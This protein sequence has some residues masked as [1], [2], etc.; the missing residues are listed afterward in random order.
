MWTAALLI[1][2]QSFLYGY[3]LAALNACLV[4]G[5]GNDSEACF[6]NDDNN[7]GGSCP[8]G[9]IY[10]D[11]NL[12]TIETSLATALMIVGA[13]AGSVFGSYPSELYGRRQT[14][15]INSLFFFLGGALSGSGNVVA[16]FIGRI[17]SGFGSGVVSCLCPVLL[18]E[19]ASE[20][21]RGIIT[22]M[23]QVL[24]TLGIFIVSMIAYGFVQYVNHGWQ[25]VQAFQAIPVIVLIAFKQFVPE[26][27]KWLFKQGRREEALQILVNLRS[28]DC[29]VNKEMNSWLSESKGSSDAEVSWGE[30]FSHQ[31]AMVIGC[32]LMF[33][34]AFT[35]INSV[36]F[37]STTIFGFAGFDQAILATASVGIVNFVVTVLSASLVDKM[38]RKILLVIGMYTMLGALA[39]LSTILYAADGGVAQGAIAVVAVLVYICGFAIGLGA[40]VWV[41]LSEIIPTRLRSKAMSLFLNI[42]WACNLVIGLGSLPA[43]DGLGGVK[44][45]MNDDAKET[46]EKNG[47]AFLYYIFMGIT[48]VAII[49]VHIFV[50]ETKGKSADEAPQVPL[51]SEY[52]EDA[53]MNGKG[54]L[55]S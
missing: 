25:Y 30:V 32:G 54:A 55:N 29:D 20:E 39:L 16:F 11:L 50:P 10:N 14:L 21:S 45:D 1:A 46:A 47:V 15:L 49:F 24:L 3:V 28:P 23:H 6:N 5:A 40:V 51:L 53:K 44:N 2:S 4:T 17:L 27:P 34:Q 18:S 37:Y 35:G 13:W 12:S 36:I 8:P 9:T 7:S 52:D 31:K 33:F 41:I 26:S 22:T 48:G 42:S 38:G 19:I 43:I